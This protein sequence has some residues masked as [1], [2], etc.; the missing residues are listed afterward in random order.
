MS[1]LKFSL[2][3]ISIE[4]AI[5]SD[6]ESRNECNPFYEDVRLP[7][8]TAPMP[9]VVDENNYMLFHENNI[10][11][12]MP[13]TI[14]YQKRLNLLNDNQWVAF[15]LEEIKQLIKE[16]HTYLLINTP[17]I[18]IDI[19]NGNMKILY[20]LVDKIKEINSSAV[21]MIGNIA[22]PDTY[23]ICCQYKIDYVRCGIGGG[24]YCLTSSNTGIYYP[25][26][27]LIHEIDKIKYQY[28]CEN[29][30]TTKIIADG[31]LKNYSDIIK[32]LALGADY[33]MCGT[34]FAQME[35]TPGNVIDFDENGKKFLK[36][37]M[38][39]M[40]S[41]IA[42]KLTGKT[43]LKT[44]EGKIGEIRIKYTMKQWRD[45]F[46]DY[47]KSAMSYTGKRT[48]NEFVGNVDILHLTQNASQSFNK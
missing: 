39:G 23:K 12:I 34:L 4:P 26:G 1:E 27:S 11:P 20:D 44:S 31:G 10:I 19:A 40:S 37:E 35:E 7:L 8:F 24:S 45:N 28:K 48:L 21:I 32:V 5:L 13:R 15:G 22:N 9:T 43:E 14:D 41:K 6:I 33:A 47:L 46:V 38:Y 17:H 42:Q 3:D 18:L 29:K 25:M 30:F 16:K 36:K 2:N